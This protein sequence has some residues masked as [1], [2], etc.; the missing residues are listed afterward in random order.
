MHACGRDARAPSRL[1]ALYVLYGWTYVLLPGS[2]AP[3]IA[4]LG[5]HPA[6]RV[7]I[8]LAELCAAAGLIRPGLTRIR[9]ELTAL[10]AAGLMIVMA[11]AAI[12][13]LMR[14]EIPMVIFTLVL[15]ALVTIVAYGRWKRAPLR[16]GTS[17]PG[18]WAC[19]GRRDTKPLVPPGDHRPAARGAG[20][21]A[22]RQHH[23]AAA[24]AVLDRVLQQVARHPLD[25]L[26]VPQAD[27]PRRVGLD[28]NAVA[29]GHLLVL[30][31]R[32]PGQSDEVRRP[33]GEL[34]RLAGGGPL[35]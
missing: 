11:S 23:L 16:A 4:S 1:A 32:A 31:G 25:P 2:A 13:H 19:S 5:L 17:G 14:G 27:R 3:M 18:A 22:Q 9:P 33:Q 8:G 34:E 6:F 29:H 21:L 20:L 24:R 30:G 35:S 28:A 10:A 12:F 26:G 7:F 15:L